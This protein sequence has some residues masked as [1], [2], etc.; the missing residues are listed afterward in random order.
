MTRLQWY[1]PIIIA[2]YLLSGIGDSRPA[3]GLCGNPRPGQAKLLQQ[4]RYTPFFSKR[5]TSV[6]IGNNMVVLAIGNPEW[7][8]VT[9][10]ATMS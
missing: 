6:A 2:S 8:D 10:V 3:S 5:L 7:Q 9:R 4:V 1:G